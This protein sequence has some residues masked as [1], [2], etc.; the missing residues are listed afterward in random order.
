MNGLEEDLFEELCKRWTLKWCFNGDT[1]HWIGNT[2]ADS[3]VLVSPGHRLAGR[4][5]VSFLIELVLDGARQHFFV[6]GYN[7]SYYFNC[8]DGWQHVRRNRRFNQ[9]ISWGNVEQLWLIGDTATCQ[10]ESIEQDIDNY[11][12]FLSARGKEWA[13]YTQSPIEEMLGEELGRQWNLIWLKPGLGYVAG[14][15][16]G[17]CPGGI[18]VMVVPQSVV[19]RYRTD[20]MLSVGPYGS[21]K[22]VIIE[23]DGHEFHEKTKEQAKRDK[24][25]DRQLAREC[26][27]LRFTGSE[28][29]QDTG[30]VVSEI[31]SFI[32]NLIAVSPAQSSEAFDDDETPF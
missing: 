15:S 5:R 14:A 25:R 10:A 3:T 8:G 2:A 6:D 30:G 13:T 1:V 16:E 18:D 20:F 31:E 7:D 32:Q 4:V 12:R 11:A 21:R 9:L 27:V 24:K 23:C 22:G 26:P 29:F 19:G 17:E 28:I